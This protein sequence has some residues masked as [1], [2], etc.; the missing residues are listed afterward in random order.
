MLTADR[1]LQYWDLYPK[2]R[3]VLGYRLLKPT[4]VLGD[5][6][7]ADDPLRTKIDGKVELG[8]RLE[9]FLRFEPNAPEL[10][11]GSEFETSMEY[12]DDE[13]HHVDNDMDP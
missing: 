11:Q 7:L 12:S 3:E 1:Y 10:I 13:D 4:F 2:Y 8:P 9:K 5:L 6:I